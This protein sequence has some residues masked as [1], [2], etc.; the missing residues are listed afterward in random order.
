[1]KRESREGNT[2]RS[3]TR[4]LGVPTGKASISFPGDTPDMLITT[5]FGK[6]SKCL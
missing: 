5:T 3:N 1:M 6:V 2:S 4:R